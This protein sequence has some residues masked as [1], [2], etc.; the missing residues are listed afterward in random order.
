MNQKFTEDLKYFYALLGER[1]KELG[2]YFSIVENEQYDER[3]EAFIDA[4]LEEI[5]LSL[6]RENRVALLG[7]LIGLRDEQMVQ[8]LEKEGKDSVFITQAK[9]K[10]YLW[11]K[12]FYLKRH[13]ALLEIVDA[14][15]LFSPFYRALLRGVHNVGIAL[16][17]WQSVW[18]EHIINTINPLLELEYDNDAK[19]IASMLH[20][21]GLYDQ[22][23]FG[24][25]ADRSYSV[26]FKI[27]GGYEA[28]AYALAFA[29]EVLHVKKA[30]EDLL[31]ALNDLEDADFGQKEAYIGYL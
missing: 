22:N 18:N 1:Q 9:E 12:A 5:E 15:A 14:K 26:L 27:A 10:A 19:A 17:D 8:A 23:T 20:E 29:K 31:F 7:R 4:F 25:D 30:L 16:S 6:V 21:K 2:G 13:E 11:V 28:K 3:I 24:E